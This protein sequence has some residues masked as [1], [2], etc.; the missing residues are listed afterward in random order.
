[1]DATKYPLDTDDIAILL[2]ALKAWENKDLAGSLMGTLLGGMLGPKEGPDFERFKA[3][4]AE[5]EAKQQREQQMR[6]EQ[7]IMLQ[8]KLISLRNRLTAESLISSTRGVK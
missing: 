6:Q 3:R 5:R 1:M 8:A 4:E 2:D 7:S